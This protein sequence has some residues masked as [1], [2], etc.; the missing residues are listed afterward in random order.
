MLPKFFF[1]PKIKLVCH[2]CNKEYLVKLADFETIC[3]PCTGEPGDPHYLSCENCI[4]GMAFPLLYTNKE[5]YT[6]TSTKKTGSN[7]KDFWSLTVNQP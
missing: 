1:K 5:G 3:D 4:G 7:G 6:F 2:Q